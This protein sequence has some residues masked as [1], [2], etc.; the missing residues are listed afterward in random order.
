MVSEGRKMKI[1]RQKNNIAI[2]KIG[3]L[4]H[5]VEITGTQVKSV[6]PGDCPADGGVWFSNSVNE[7][8]VQYVSNGRSRSAAFSAF[9]R[10]VP[11][12]KMTTVRFEL[13]DKTLAD[14]TT[15]LVSRH[16][17]DDECEALRRAMIKHWGRDVFL[18]LGKRILAIGGDAL[19]GKIY[20]P[21]KYEHDSPRAITGLLKITIE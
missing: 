16:K 21:G 5:V 4:Y 1:I 13:V 3:Y 20:I 17:T 6:L 2:I 9:R 19:Y 12:Y 11:G 15:E 18:Q 10:L 8:G 7:S 14:G